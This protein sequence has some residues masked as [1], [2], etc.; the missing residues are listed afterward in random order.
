MK[1]YLLDTGALFLIL[2]KQ[3]PQ[4]WKR[5]LTE[6]KSQVK[7]LIL[8]EPII[9]ELAYHLIKRGLDKTELQTKLIQIKY[10]SKIISLEDKYSIKAAYYRKNLPYNLSLVDRYILA[11][12]KETRAK[13]ITTDHKIKFAA[14]KEGIKV[15]YLPIQK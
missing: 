5:Y 6:I 3:T 7:R 12:A 1:N 14:R 4:K 2:T 10:K 11:I 13:I 9:A 15:D 8:I